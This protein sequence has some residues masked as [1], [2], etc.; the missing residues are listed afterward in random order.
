ME[1]VLSIPGIQTAEPWRIRK[2]SPS[3]ILAP[4]EGVTDAPMRA[5]LSE[6]GGFSFCVSEF[7][8]ISQEL[9]PPKV[10]HA[11]VPELAKGSV[12]PAGLPVQFQLL[13]GNP[14]L[15]AEAAWRACQA[16]A[17]GIDLNFGCPAPIVN[18]HDGG[19]ALLKYPERIRKIVEAVRQRVPKAIPV[20]V[21]LRLGWDSIDSIHRNAEEAAAGGADWL[22][23][24]GRTKVQGYTPPAY[25]KPIG[26]VQKRLGIAVVA[27]GEI[28]S[29][30]EFR[31]CRDE[32][33]C[34]HLG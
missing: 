10:F 22:T 26:E 21:K 16:G 8:R 25:W 23:I 18:R 29:L 1:S 19:A 33:G 28:W 14:E 6:I 4:M 11:H 34:E 5:L 7:L 13:G 30:E 20:S 32:T 12:T 27:N 9:P 3:L 31:R 24:H 2:G 15:L 17:C